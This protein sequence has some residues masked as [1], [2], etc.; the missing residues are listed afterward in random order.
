MK[1][2]GI[3]PGITICGYAVLEE[4][5]QGA[6]SQGHGVIRNKSETP[7]SEQLN[8]LHLELTILIKKFQP[9]VLAVE[10]LFF[11]TNIKTALS[12]GHARG[13]ILLAGAQKNLPV[14]E[15]SPMDVKI[16]MTGYGRASKEQI[17][18]MVKT[19]LKLPEIPR[20][21]D[22]ADALA[23]ALCHLNSYKVVGLQGNLVR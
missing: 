10:K 18:I 20:P 17:Q 22:A 9:D 11:G 3:D 5:G 19:L 6:S 4:K 23:I 16:A 21:D 12:V 14:F 1:V 15:Y 7:L 2:L 13:V 8:K